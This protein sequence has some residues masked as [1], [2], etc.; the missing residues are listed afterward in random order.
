ME[1][2]MNIELKASKLRLDREIA[3]L[4][5]A[6]PASQVSPQIAKLKRDHYARLAEIKKGYGVLTVRD[7]T[8]AKGK[9]KLPYFPRLPLEI[10]NLVWKHTLPGPRIVPLQKGQVG[11]LMSPCV[12]PVALQ[13]CQSSRREA[14]RQGY[15]LAFKND[16]LLSGGNHV[17][18]VW[19]NF[20]IDTFYPSSHLIRE[21]KSPQDYERVISA[22]STKMI[23][24]L[25]FESQGMWS[26]D[27]D[28]YFRL[29]NQVFPCLEKVII[30]QQV[31]DMV[32][33]HGT[34]EP[35]YLYDRL[36]EQSLP[37][38]VG[39]KKSIDM[40]ESNEVPKLPNYRKPTFEAVI[41]TDRM[42]AKWMSARF[43][44]KQVSEFKHETSLYCRRRGWNTDVVRE[45]AA[46]NLDWFNNAAV[47]F[48]TDMVE[49]MAES[50]E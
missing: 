43:R 31:S 19:F 46:A 13:V 7:P 2:P 15:I 18:G 36:L 9:A 23:R 3:S 21:L 17:S 22:S 34:Q 45:D 33:G 27:D 49:I 14:I 25:G 44:A 16:N 47:N 42:I 50:A 20:N 12:T 32:L 41:L 11:R 35:Y 38:V 26:R 10:Q 1:N 28:E 24:K 29:N 37:D 39:C 48:N 5:K 40:W 30:I 8:K 6:W 4:T